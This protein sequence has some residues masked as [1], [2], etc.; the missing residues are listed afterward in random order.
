M[1]RL[2]KELDNDERSVNTRLYK[3]SNFFIYG[4]DANDRMARTSKMNMI[5]HGDGHGGIHHHDGLLNVN[6]IFENRFDV[7]PYK[8]ANLDN[9]VTKE[10]VVLETD[11]VMRFATDAELRY[12]PDEK[13]KPRDNYSEYVE[14]Y[15]K[16]YGKEAYQ[17]AQL[18]ILENIGKPIA[19]LFDLKPNLMA[20]KTQH[21][22]INRCLD[23]LKPSGRFRNC[24]R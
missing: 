20:D 4:T 1:I 11:S 9:R 13:I 21:L 24:F 15:Y 6:G 17:K 8:S 22:F 10:N 18:K 2:Q 14:E 12:E 16:R 7:Y 19:S 23:L 3:L 5:M